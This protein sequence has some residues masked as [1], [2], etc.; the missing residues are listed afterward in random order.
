MNIKLPRLLV[1]MASIACFGAIIGLRCLGSTEFTQPE[2]A[3]IPAAKFNV[4]DFGAKGDGVTVNTGAIQQ[5]IDACAK[6]GGGQVIIPSGTFFSG[7]LKLRS[8]SALVLEKGALLKGSPQFS[9]FGLPSPLPATQ[10]E[11]DV[12]YKKIPPLISGDKLQ[13]VA[14]LGQGVIDGNGP[15]WWDRSDVRI[16]RGIAPKEVG[17]VYIPRPHLVILEDCIRVHI[18][19]VTLKD[20]PMFH[21][22]PKRCKEVLVEDIAILSPDEAPNADGIDPSNSSNMLIRRC[23]I[24]TGDDNIAFK[25]GGGKGA[26]PCE[27]VVI[28]NCRFLAG[29]GLSIGSE[30]YSGVRNILVKDCT[31]EGTTTGLRIKSGRTRGGP[32]ENITYQN[33]TMKNVGTAFNIDLFYDDKAGKKEPGMAPVTATTPKVKGVRFVNIKCDGATKRAG[34]IYG[35]RSLTPSAQ[36]EREWFSFS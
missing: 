16:K 14:I 4:V 5:A 31:F 22:V 8:R 13:D 23:L 29:H 28:S 12:Y 34:M 7:P 1:R 33:I 2:A 36:A 9:D 35:W 24:D 25:G 21:L 27:N 30:T 32:V 17:S 3:V 18:Q 10:A 6:A 11:A 15:M 26:P 20:S 19:G